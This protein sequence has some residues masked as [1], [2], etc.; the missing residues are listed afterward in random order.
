M[1]IAIN[2][3]PYASY[4]GIETYTVN[5]I[6]ALARNFPNDQFILLK[7]PFSPKFLTVAAPNVS[8]YIIPVSGA[9]KYLLAIAQQIKV[10]N[11]MRE[12]GADI[13]FC[14]S[15]A[16]PLFLKNKI[17]TIHDCA[18]DR[19]PESTNIFLKWY[20]KAMFYAA[21]YRSR[22]VVTI[23]E[24]SKKELVDLYGFRAER[25]HA[26]Y[27]A[28]PELPAVN[29]VFQAGMLEKFGI[30]KGKY[31]FSIGN[32]RPRKNIGGLLGAFARFSRLQDYKLVLA[33]K[34][35]TRF[36]DVS[37]EA[38]K[39]GIASHVIQTDF[40]SDEEKVALY[41]GAV[42]LAFP[43]YYEGFGFPVLEAQSLG[44]P[45]ITSN[46]SSL[47]EVGGSQGAVY[48]DPYNVQS[49]ASAMEKMVADGPLHEELIAAGREN[50]KRF[51]WDKTAKETMEV[52]RV[53]A[54]E[55]GTISL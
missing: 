29:D 11:A 17:V 54:Q 45:V 21:K 53:A 2:L 24:F 31:F 50:V 55:S 36:M 30:E 33:G 27:S 35:D 3:L 7:S 4:Q 15:P 46:T 32:T 8:E 44:V 52:L 37:T 26:I 14:T 16:G 34:M 40:I 43:S 39:L 51:S 22:G 25:V 10:K 6:S 28:L 49:I 9:R 38:T 13:L 12:T 19:F 20:F 5:L 23:S 41:K 18:Y 47:P 42:A 1:K 48:V